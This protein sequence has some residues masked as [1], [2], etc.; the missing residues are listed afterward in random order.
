MHLYTLFSKTIPIK[1]QNGSKISKT[2]I[3]V[4][5]LVNHNNKLTLVDKTPSPKSR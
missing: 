2:K 3:F 5:S 1:I 4:L